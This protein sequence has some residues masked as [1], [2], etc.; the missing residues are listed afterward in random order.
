MRDTLSWTAWFVVAGVLVAT[1][2]PG[3]RK[4]EQRPPPE[5]RAL[6]K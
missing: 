2:M 3:R 4:E 1:F 6:L 5:P